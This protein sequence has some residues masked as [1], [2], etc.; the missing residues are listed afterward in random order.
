MW[1]VFMYYHITNLAD[2]LSDATLRRDILNIIHNV[3][4]PISAMVLDNSVVRSDIAYYLFTKQ[5]WNVTVALN[6]NYINRKYPLKVLIHGWT[7]HNYVEWY[8]NTAKAY[9]K[10][11]FYNVIAIDWSSKGD[12]DYFTATRTVR[13]V[14]RKIGEF[15]VDL[16]DRKGVPYK[17]MH[18]ISHSLGC[19]VAGFAGKRSYELAKRKLARITGLDPAAPIFDLT[20]DPGSRLSKEDADFVD[21]IHTDGGMLGFNFPIG[22]VDFFPNGGTAIQPGC[23]LLKLNIKYSDFFCSHA[24]SHQL[25]INSINTRRFTAKP[26]ESWEKFSKGL[27]ND[28]RSITFGENVPEIV[29][30]N[31]YLETKEFSNA[32]SF[33][34]RSVQFSVRYP[35]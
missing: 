17:N 31:F 15:L 35:V 18:L 6:G 16:H 13:A 10:K 9:V 27:C 7:E 23:S 5:H 25:F 2:G 8:K 32:Y 24:S 14:G 30:G 26:C 22:T 19:H 3:S 11:G 33:I 20:M 21:V 29:S 1:S 4:F 34:Y 28:A 12:E